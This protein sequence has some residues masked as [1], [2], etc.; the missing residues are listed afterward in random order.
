VGPGRAGLALGLAL[1]REGEARELVYCGRRPDPPDHPLFREGAA[2]Y[3]YGVELPREGTTALFL[4]VPDDAIQEMAEVVA[5]QGA[6]PA[7]C[8]AFHLS[9]ALST[10][11]L[12]PLH[13]RGYSTGSFHPLLSLAD[14][15][16]GAGRF[17][18]STVAISGDA[19]AL[20]T[21]RRIVWGLGA[22]PLTMA[23]GLRPFHHAA[24]VLLSTGLLV[25]VETAGR[26]LARAGVGREESMD[27]LVPLAMGMLEDLRK[28]GGTEALTGPV[29][30]GDVE[31]I[32]LHLRALG[33]GDADL[34]RAVGR[35]VL[36]LAGSRI[37]P[38]IQDELGALFASRDPRDEDGLMTDTDSTSAS[39]EPGRLTP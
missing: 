34:Y 36:E 14:A 24:T 8:A 9:G 30:R 27:A 3:V 39:P 37:D 13:L 33:E 12:V 7:G 11:V 16:E 5:R 4:S 23:T 31:T 6:P 18:G 28:L 38:E 35:Q 29:P 15:V 21:A 32:R 22:R 25:L 26:L 17:R 19:G 20:V 1:Y 10:D 2:R